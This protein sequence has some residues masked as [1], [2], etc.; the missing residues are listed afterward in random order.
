VS[1][2]A[3]NR[4]GSRDSQTTTRSFAIDGQISSVA[5][6]FNRDDAPQRA[7]ILATG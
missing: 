7:R 1:A 6:E 4:V 5:T 2:A 3:A